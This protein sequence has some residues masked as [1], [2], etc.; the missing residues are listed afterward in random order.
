MHY[1]VLRVVQYRTQASLTEQ[2]T[3]GRKKS[4]ET[5]SA[6][7]CANADGIHRLKSAVVGK[8]KM[9]ILPIVYYNSENASFTQ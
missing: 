1:T 5:L 3:R 9:R 7:L 4:K 6:L 2:S 8:A